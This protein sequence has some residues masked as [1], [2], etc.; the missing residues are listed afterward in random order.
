RGAASRWVSCEVSNG[1][2][3]ECGRDDGVRREAELRL[4]LLE[5]GGCAEG[6]HADD[7]ALTADVALPAERRRL[8]DRDARGHRGRQHRF[9]VLLGLALEQRP[10]R[11][12]HDTGAYALRVEA[13]IG[14]NREVDLGT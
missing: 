3:V 2:L 13:L 8:L 7:R 6:A 5:R 10:R 14:L 4:Q 1:E 12:R 11:H 9:A